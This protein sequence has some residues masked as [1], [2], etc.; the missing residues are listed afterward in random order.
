MKTIRGILG[1]ALILTSFSSA[2]PNESITLSD[3]PDSQTGQ[4]NTSDESEWT[5]LL[6]EGRATLLNG[7]PA[8]AVEKYFNP[9]IAHYETTYKDSPQQLFCSDNNK[10]SLMY[11]MTAAVAVNLGKENLPDHLMPK[12]FLAAG[13]HT[14]DPKAETVVLSSTWAEAY[15]LKAYAAIETGR[16][17]E[18]LKFLKKALYLSPNNTT[19]WSELGH[20]HQMLK[21]WESS[22][23][24]FKLAEEA[25]S[26]SEEAARDS[27]RTRAWRGIGFPYIEQGKLDQAEALFKQC[28]ELNPEDRKA[29]NELNYIAQV[30]AKQQSH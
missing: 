14:L 26:V 25:A 5:A 3:G 11:L 12:T 21:N 16:T 2:E 9:V 27:D 13:R 18:A 7:N 6:M 10:Q 4:A 24:I 19:Y 28:L 23:K 29:Q 22:I 17:D 1:A 20:V 30:K 8:T 15:F